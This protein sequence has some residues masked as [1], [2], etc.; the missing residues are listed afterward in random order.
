[1]YFIVLAL[2]LYAQWFSMS[3][4]ISLIEE[5]VANLRIR[6][7]NKLRHVD[8][9]FYERKSVNI[10]YNRLTGDNSALSNAIPQITVAVQFSTLVFFSLIYMAF[11]SPIS[12]FIAVSGILC[13][14]FY[15]LM[16]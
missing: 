3:E 16:L 8:L 9:S 5:A 1:M 12:F 11:I 2:F 10:L 7:S 15:F 14:Y 4:A 13:G 6:L